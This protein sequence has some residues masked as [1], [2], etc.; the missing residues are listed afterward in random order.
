MQQFLPFHINLLLVNFLVQF[1]YNKAMVNDMTQ[2]KFQ[3]SQNYCISFLLDFQ[4]DQ[5]ISLLKKAFHLKTHRS[6]NILYSKFIFENFKHSLLYYF[7][8]DFEFIASN[9]RAKT[10]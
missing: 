6:N 10:T 2:A 7:I 5:H 1:S 8:D 9:Q 3:R 4:K